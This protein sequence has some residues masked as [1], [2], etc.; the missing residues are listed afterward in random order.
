MPRH[1][2]PDGSLP[3]S[4]EIYVFGSNL[5]GR[6]GAG[7]ALVARQR[8]G[9][10]YGQARGLQGR[11][12]A[13]PTKDGRPGAPSLRD[14]RSTRPLA[15]IAKDVDVFLAFARA[16]PELRFFVV[17]LGCSLASHRNEDIAPLFQD[18]P[19]NCAFVQDWAPWLGGLVQPSLF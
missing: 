4:G 12:Y 5:A 8:F 18:A 7:S 3:Q 14:A 13:I 15:D 11:S 19:D 9:A 17:R 16:H 2:H 10:V 6:H 1:F